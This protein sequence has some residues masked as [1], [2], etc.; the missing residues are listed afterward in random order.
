[1]GGSG[2]GW[3]REGWGYGEGLKA[4]PFQRGRSEREESLRRSGASKK[5]WDHSSRAGIREVG[6]FRKGAA[7]V[8]KERGK[9]EPV[10]G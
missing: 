2:K 4:R 6:P 9:R 8:G 10:I 3:G 5:G 7:R 1:M